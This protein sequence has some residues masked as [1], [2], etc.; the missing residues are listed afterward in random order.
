M[1]LREEEVGR[2]GRGRGGGHRWVREVGKKEVKRNG[3]GR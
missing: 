3:G 1:S 2:R